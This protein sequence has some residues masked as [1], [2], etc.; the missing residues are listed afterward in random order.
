MC[1]TKRRI[2]SVT[3]VKLEFHRKMCHDVCI[4]INIGI[5]RTKRPDHN[6]EKQVMNNVDEPVDRICM[7]PL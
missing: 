6:V 1:L 7:W 2:Y 4:V 3:N 5:P